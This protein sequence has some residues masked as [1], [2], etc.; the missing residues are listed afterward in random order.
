MLE[1]LLANAP[2]GERFIDAG[3]LLISELVTNAVVHGTPMGRRVQLVVSVDRRRLRIEV[4]D[5]R[6]ERGPVIRA[7]S[8]EDESGRGMMIVKSLAQRWGCCSREGVGKMVWV[9]VEPG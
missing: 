4:H 3:Q 8:G 5:A 2:G 7:A 6:G 1:R 9:E